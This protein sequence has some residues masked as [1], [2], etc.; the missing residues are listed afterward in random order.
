MIELFVCINNWKWENL[1]CV[2]YTRYMVQF[3]NSD[4]PGKLVSKLKYDSPAVRFSE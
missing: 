4:I 1:D 2:L 3:S